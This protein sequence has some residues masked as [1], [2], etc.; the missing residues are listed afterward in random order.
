MAW[1]LKEFKYL[2]TPFPGYPHRRHR[3]SGK[4]QKT[5]KKDIL[6]KIVDKE[7]TQEI[8]TALKGH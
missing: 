2:K 1:N 4:P 8:V 5:N 7:H 3:K 6:I